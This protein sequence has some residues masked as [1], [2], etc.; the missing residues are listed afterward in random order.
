MNNSPLWRNK[1]SLNEGAALHD[2]RHARPLILR[3]TKIFKWPPVNRNGIGESDWRVG[4]EQDRILEVDARLSSA[5]PYLQ[6]G[7]C[8]DIRNGHRKL[9]IT[10][11]IPAFF[12][13]QIDGA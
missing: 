13:Q 3:L 7:R 5:S 4:V 2:D 12:M 8:G 9:G 6:V 1:A 11:I 10:F